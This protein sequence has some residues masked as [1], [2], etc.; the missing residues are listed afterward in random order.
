MD[1]VNSILEQSEDASKSINV[2]K[3]IELDI[4]EGTL[5]VSDYNTIDTDRFRSDK[6][7]YLKSLTR[8]NTQLLINKIWALP[9]E[10]VDD[11]VI[12][13][14]PKPKYILPRARVVPKPKPLTKWQKFAKEKGIQ[15]NKKNKSKLMW[16]EELRQWIPTYGYKRAKAQQQKEWLMEVGDDNTPKANP[17]ETASRA[18]EERVAKN[19]LQRLRNLARTKNV[20]I[21]R[22]GLPTTEQLASSK[23]LAT[24]LTVARVSTASVGKFQ[25]KLPKEKDAK[26][27][28]TKVTGLKKKRKAPPLNM[29]DEKKRNTE[30]V[31]DIISKKTTKDILQ[32]QDIPTTPSVSSEVEKKKGKSKKSIGSKKPKAGKGKR[33]LHKKVGGRKRR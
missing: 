25:N 3:P 9:T 12:A 6:D 10:R 28:T 15:K 19:E 14:L 13:K 26:G 7:E 2:D 22:V 27:I 16:D 20:K 33:D 23:H 31:N 1:I 18:K 8:D 21:P 24:A 11:V 5:L 29:V 4:D 30:L 32:V 17:R